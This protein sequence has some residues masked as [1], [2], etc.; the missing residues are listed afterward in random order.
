MWIK[1]PEAVKMYARFCEARY[2]T[3]A[4]KTVR[5]K[6]QQLKLKGDLQGH[7]IWIDVAAEIE[8]ASVTHSSPKN[9]Q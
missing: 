2:G 1:L 7:Q 3:S 5:E 4:S 6:A 9:A 8:H